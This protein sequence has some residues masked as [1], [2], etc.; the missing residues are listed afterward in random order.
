MLYTSKEIIE[1]YECYE[2]EELTST[3]DEIKNIKDLSIP[4][5]ITAINQT[6][7]RGR[8][9]RNWTPILGN[10][11]FSYNVENYINRIFT[12]RIKG[13]TLRIYYKVV[14]QNTIL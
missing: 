5:L 2:F 4:T 13:Y 7:G 8:R 1:N 6:K 14:M 3:N 11:Y 10:L 9:A 12:N